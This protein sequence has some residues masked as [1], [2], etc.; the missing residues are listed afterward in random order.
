[1]HPIPLNFNE[2]RRV[3]LSRT[4]AFSNRNDTHAVLFSEEFVDAL[5][6]DASDVREIIE[7]I[8]IIEIPRFGQ[9]LKKDRGVVG[10]A[11]SFLEMEHNEL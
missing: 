6:E 8:E 1:M 4:R 9:S 3:G 2:R 11:R 5:M 10:S 7:I